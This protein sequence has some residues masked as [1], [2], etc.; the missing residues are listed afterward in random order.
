ME[1]TDGD[2]FHV[3]NRGNQQQQIF[4]SE[5]NYLFF[6]TKMEKALLPHAHLLAYC[7]MPNHFHWLVQIKIAE[8][9]YTGIRK[10]YSSK[11]SNSMAVL[12]RSYAR[13]IQKQERFT[14][15][16]FQQNSKSKILATENDVLNCFN[17]IHQNPVKPGLVNKANDWKH[18]SL[19]EFLPNAKDRLCDVNLLFNLAGINH[20][21][22]FI[23]AGQDLDDDQIKR[24][25]AS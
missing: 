10:T 22:D 20:N 19:S 7:L 17:H 6:L 8:E 24:I 9:D 15:S 2:V 18:S 13:A 4:F 21:Y 1:L 14:G 12:L 16:L 5:A 3:Y 25:F 23:N 11:F